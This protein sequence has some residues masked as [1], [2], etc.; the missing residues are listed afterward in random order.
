M[1]L[2]LLFVVGAGGAGALW[3]SKGRAD[4][5]AVRLA[6]PET[7]ELPVPPDEVTAVQTY[8]AGEGAAVVAFARDVPLLRADGDT[9]QVADCK[10]AVDQLDSIGSPPVLARQIEGIPDRPTQD[11]A[12]SYFAASIGYLDACIRGQEPDGDD[13]RFTSEVLRRRLEQLGV[14]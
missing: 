13:L 6:D 14:A 11:M 2:V 8:L 4:E 10:S 7:V 5:S 3:W 1:L 12:T 9:P